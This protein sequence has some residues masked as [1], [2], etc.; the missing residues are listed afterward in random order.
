MEK[1]KNNKILITIIAIFA[2]ITLL[3]AGYIVYDKVLSKEEQP[4]ETTE[5]PNEIEEETGITENEEYF[6]ELLSTFLSHAGEYMKNYDSFSD[7]DINTYLYFYYVE[8]AHKNNLEKYSSDGVTITY[9]V[10][11]SELDSQVLKTFGKPEYE[12][13]EPKFRGGIKKID[14]NTYQVS[15]FAT[16]WYNPDRKISDI[17]KSNN[18][19]IITYTLTGNEV[20]GEEGKLLGTLKFYLKKND[21][22][23]NVTKIEYIENK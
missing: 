3:L 1:E 11:K 10:S 18:E 16:G 4:I 5:K 20:F 22:N 23:Y 21:G 7:E 19:A 15:W 6:N 17:T 12:Y 14:D 8:Y 9:D 13:V 2:I